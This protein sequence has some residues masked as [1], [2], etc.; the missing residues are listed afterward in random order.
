MKLFVARNLNIMQTTLVDIDLLEF[1]SGFFL[2][3]GVNRPILRE[4]DP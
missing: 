3:F 1:M 2:L 4:N